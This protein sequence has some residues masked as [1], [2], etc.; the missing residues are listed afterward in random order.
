[1]I[2]ALRQQFNY[3]F[4]PQKYAH[5]LKLL[6]QRC[7]T[8]VQ[9]RICETPCFFPRSLLEKMGDYGKELIAQL[10]TPEYHEASSQA[11]PPEFNAP[12]EASH[13]MFVQVDFGLG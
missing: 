11:I 4:T 12:N 10:Q 13:P 1:M 5:L 8:P 3:N 6:E 2:P 9:F 7:G